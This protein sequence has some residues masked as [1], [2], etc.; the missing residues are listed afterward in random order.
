MSKRQQQGFT[1]LEI[2]LVIVLLGMIALAVVM[3]MP[4]NILKEKDLKWQA[5]RFMTLLAFAQDEALIS[6]QEFGIVLDNDQF[7]FALYQHDK[8]KWLASTNERVKG[9]VQIGEYIR[10]SHELTGSIWDE[11]DQQDEDVF[12][13]PSYLV[14]IEDD[15]EEKP[16][17]PQIFVM[18]S[19]EVTPFTLTFTLEEAE[20]T[21][22][23]TLTVDSTGATK[24]SEIEKS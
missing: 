14:Q 9:T 22:A 1:L 8:K 10:M 4:N 7:E 16:L 5:Q 2:M 20:Q 13:D 12:I 24:L 3:T 23:L 18:S 19:G 15:E 17:K 21:Q 11:I 6:G